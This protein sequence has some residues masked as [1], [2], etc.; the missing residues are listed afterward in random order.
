MRYEKAEDIKKEAERIIDK[1]DLN[2]IDKNNIECIRSFGSKG[3][4]IARCHGLGKAMQLGLGR[5]AFYVL[6]FLERFDKQSKEERI[7][8]II[9]E[10]LHIPNNFG[11]GFKYHNFVNKKRVEKMY[12]KLE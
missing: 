11:G 12:R 1:L 8:T 5:K 4:A 7:K 9:H 10:L 3:R 2:H 6:E